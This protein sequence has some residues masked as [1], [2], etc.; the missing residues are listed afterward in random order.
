MKRTYK[1]KLYRSKKNR[2]LH[3][4]I[5][6]AAQVYNHCL[7]LQRRYYR[8]T[9]KYLNLY[10]LQAFVAKLKKRAKFQHWK[11]LGS[12]A[13]QDVIERLDKGYQLFFSERAK[14]NK[15]IRPPKFKKSRD[16]RSFTLKQS[17]YKYL[18]DN[19]VQ[20]GKRN[21]DFFGF[22]EIDGTIK[23]LTISRDSLGDLFICF[24]CDVKNDASESLVTTGQTAGFDLG[25][26]TFL[27]SSDGKEWV[28][29]Q[30]LKTALKELKTADR[31]LS[32][33][34]RGSQNWKRAKKHLARVHRRITNVRQD[35][36]WKLARELVETYDELY[37]ETLAFEGFKARW[38]RK[39]S[40][41]A[42]ASFL[43]KVDYLADMTGKFYGQIDR[44]VPSSK[45]CCECL[46][47]NESLKLQDREWTCSC[48]TSHH[49][50]ISAA[51]NIHRVGISTHKGVGSKTA[52]VAASSDDLRS[53]RL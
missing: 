31:S 22:R 46:A 26:K 12:Q 40:D 29:P 15:K 36:Q 9:K 32:S 3:Q 14:G 5:F 53:P 41:L 16:Y 44:W 38:G 20:I 35:F 13:I 19:R 10:R 21:Y 48:G 43:S 47:I 37:F 2:L 42:F 1:F 8:L 7:A 51:K 45:T 25:L 18:G 33:K 24:S 34:V 52:L 30:P 50:D 39:T 11:E 23:R 4:R 28:A 6:L 49:R 27:T 17:G